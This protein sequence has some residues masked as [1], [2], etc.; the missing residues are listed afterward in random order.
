MVLSGSSS[1]NGDNEK[2]LKPQ[3][4]QPPSDIEKEAQLNTKPQLQ[5]HFLTPI[6][7]K[8]VPP[9]PDQSEKKLWPRSV[10]HI[11]KFIFFWWL[12]PLMSVGYKR[13][14]ENEDLWTLK[15]SMEV[16]TLYRIFCDHLQK[17]AIKN[18][19]KAKAKNPN[20]S[21]E[22]LHE[23]SL[24]KFSI[25][26]ALFK[27]LKLRYLMGV[28]CKV[29]FDVAS[30]L[31]PL[32]SKAL[33]NYVEKKYYYPDLSLRKGV[34]YALGTSFV[35]L[36]S[37]ILINH[38]FNFSMTCGV[39]VKAILTKLVLDK[40][41][42]LD[43]K[44][45]QNFT[46][47]KITSIMGTD[48][49]RVDLAVG[50]QPFLI[51]FP[52]PVAIT[53][54]LL[55]VNIGP[56][57]LV[58]VGIFIMTSVLIT[59]LSKNLLKF[60]ITAS[61]Y[62]DDR[63]S[64][65]REVLSS[66]KMIKYYGWEVPYH[67]NIKNRRH[68]EMKVVLKMQLLRVVFTAVAICLPTICSVVTFLV[69]FHLHPHKS[70]ADLFSSLSLFSNLAQL[71]I[72]IP[73][74]L[75][76]S[77]DCFIGLQRV[78]DL[79]QSSEEKS[80][81]PE[82]EKQQAI[83]NN[84]QPDDSMAVQVKNAEFKWDSIDYVKNEEDDVLKSGHSK[85]HNAISE[86]SLSR[87]ATRASVNSKGLSRVGTLDV[88][89]PSS[90][91]GLHKISFDIKR[92]EFVIIT[93]T[94]GS[95]KTS[96][97]NAI[98]GFMKKKTG[99]LEVKDSLLLCGYPWVQNATIREN[100]L[101]G[102]EYDAERY[103]K[104][105][106][107]CALNADLAVLP[108]GDKTE[109]GERGITL[110]GGQ[111]A[112]IN[113]ARAVYND[114]DIILLDDVLSAVDARVGK[115]IMQTC[116]IDFLKEK[117]RFLA[118]HQLSLI[119]YAD[120][121]IFITNEGE[122]IV[123][124]VDELKAQNE[125]FSKLM[126]FSNQL[127]EEEEEEVEQQEQ[128]FLN[129]QHQQILNEKVAVSSAVVPSESHLSKRKSV[130]AKIDEEDVD[131][132]YQ[133]KQGDGT[134]VKKEERAVNK[135]KW[136]VYKNY[137]TVGVGKKAALPSVVFLFLLVALA[138]FC[139]LF[140]NVWLSFWTEDRFHKG[141]SFYMGLYAMFCFIALFLTTFEFG[142]MVFL[143]NRSAKELNLRAV[144][145]VLYTPMSFIDTTPMGRILNRFTKDTDALDNE[146]GEQIRLFVFPTATVVGVLILTI[147]YLPWIAIAIPGI[148]IIFVSI[149][150]FY[151]ASA[152]EVKRLE[153]VNRSFVFNN[154]EECLSGVNTIKAYQL[155]SAFIKKSDKFINLMNEAYYV[156]VA[157][158]RWLAIHL[159]I[160]AFVFIL[161]V[162]LLCVTRQFNI[163]ASSTGLV[164]SYVMN[165]VGL[166]SLLI[167]SLT[168][169]E[170]EMNS[171]ERMIQYATDMPQEAPYNIEETKP[172][173]DWPQAGEITFDNVDMKYRE[174][175]PLVL[176]DLSFEVLPGEKI[177]ICGRTGAGKSSLMTALYRLAELERGRIVIDGIDI[178]SLGLHDLRSKLCIIP[179]DPVLFKGSIRK[180][181]DPFGNSNDEKLWDA[182]RR[183][184]LI[185]GTH[186]PTIKKQVLQDENLESLHKF[187]LD[188]QV[189][190]EGSN[191]SLGERQLL[192]LARALVRDSK[193]LILDE[194]TSSVD[195][196][197][198]A[199]INHTIRTEFSDCTI[200]CIA[201]RLNTIVKFDKIMVLDKGTVAEF[202][203]P[204]DLFNMKDGIF[205]E[206]CERSQITEG[207]F[208][209]DVVE[210]Q[211]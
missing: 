152:R 60:R 55:I 47:G 130:A 112:R 22:E 107:V 82:F 27:T 45:R 138:T 100:I 168:Q 208:A 209:P 10:K 195:Y 2:D 26:I 66:I 34:G 108:A 205:R 158:Q 186:L 154:F 105:V 67:E 46:T 197:T 48:L 187:H 173:A 163:S 96:L 59:M 101:F 211:S 94:I 207:D 44:A 57:A 83:A 17:I 141:K 24:T 193:I 194:A 169:V 16:E 146:I 61:K 151:Q 147:I 91:T 31:N 184:G 38:T 92:G 86:H 171:A 189:E 15:E 28:L 119:N 104:V 87:Q 3:F 41:F 133:N 199:N 32:L 102:K 178:A 202:G 116:I 203:K 174:G 164:L 140:T 88:V 39:Q 75:A 150:S 29:L 204:I 85:H 1:S 23:L 21:D 118:T 121:V 145:N 123:G 191:F 64:L 153:A 20:L 97:L 182:L 69:L 192:A 5:R 72:M 49:A 103:T 99:V 200:L 65:V 210:Q 175:L 177:G 81:D 12:H 113:L 56:V 95:G 155:Q 136:D 196:E 167:R 37:G 206:M 43:G 110:S 62:T 127:E 14:L 78:K 166:L 19:E 183:S 74:A 161:I 4:S 190:E 114:K 165:I 162:S 185:E 144:R 63:V 180:N 35:V 157:I 181:L 71:V 89:D 176:H 68:R 25:P 198:D 137:L 109:V 50:F 149:T 172:P 179:Q 117:T 160:T 106:H 33:I 120:R 201:H 42:R 128:E 148:V 79:L 111:K 11:F 129:D 6:L 142:F 90:F 98:A 51:S 54:A 122:A 18:K 143:I 139:Q 135:I 70:P 77:I 134:L 53:I 93:G 170:N 9:V 156:N 73:M 30:A 159:D 84:Y 80:A 131:Y 58:G 52:V 125:D 8:S 76:S 36:I 40:A 126:E 115:H 188:Q 124:T 7:P 13:T 132:D